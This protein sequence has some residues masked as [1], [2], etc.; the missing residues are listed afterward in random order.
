MSSQVSD[1]RPGPALG[2]EARAL[3]PYQIGTRY[4]TVWRVPWAVGRGSADAAALDHARSLPRG[5]DTGGAFCDR[6]PGC[7]MGTR[8][9]NTGVTAAASDDT[10][11]ECRSLRS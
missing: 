5:G 2:P 3:G 1:L 6:D 8:Q 10:V 9:G 7:G 11:V 4:R